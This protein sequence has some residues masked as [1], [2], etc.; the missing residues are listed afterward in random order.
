M[1]STQQQA[2][3]KLNATIKNENDTFV[4]ELSEKVGANPQ[5]I[6]HY[7][8]EAQKAKKTG[9]IALHKRLVDK[10]DEVLVTKSRILGSAPV[11]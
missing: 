2:L 9:K 4:N 5:Q 11:S 3:K 1:K 6:D 10:L 8:E 7:F